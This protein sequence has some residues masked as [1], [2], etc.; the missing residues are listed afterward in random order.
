MTQSDWT[1]NITPLTA[2]HVEEVM[3]HIFRVERTEGYPDHIDLGKS[4][5]N[6]ILS[7]GRVSAQDLVARY[8]SDGQKPGKGTIILV[9]IGCKL[10]ADIQEQGDARVIACAKSVAAWLRHHCPGEL[11]LALLLR[12]VTPPVLYVAV[13]PTHADGHLS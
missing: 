13:I 11:V 2:G 8:T 5:R 9:G 12:D 4:R 10:P 6:K 3:A 7:G 1:L